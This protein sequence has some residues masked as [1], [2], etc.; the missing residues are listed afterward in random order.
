MKKKKPQTPKD[1]ASNLEKALSGLENNTMAAITE[2]V[3]EA[4]EDGLW[5]IKGNFKSALRNLLWSL[6]IEHEKD[7]PRFL[8][9]IDTLVDTIIES[10]YK[11]TWG[12]HGY[13]E[14]KVFPILKRLSKALQEKGIEPFEPLLIEEEEK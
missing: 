11:N 10:S 14:S 9:D 13:A 5:N 7:S 12:G 6:G 8:E 2:K 1:D 4:I 3:Q